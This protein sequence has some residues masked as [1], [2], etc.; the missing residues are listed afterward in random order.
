LYL[1]YLRGQGYLTANR[2]AEAASE[3]QVI[4]DHPG[5]VRNAPIGALVHCELARAYASNDNTSKSK[6]AY[7]DFFA[8]WKDADSDVPILRQ[9]RAEYERMR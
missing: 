7:E 4:L 3:F 1:T 8:L 5:L 2:Q 9:A 6:A